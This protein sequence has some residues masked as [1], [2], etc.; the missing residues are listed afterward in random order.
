MTID[1]ANEVDSGSDS[2]IITRNARIPAPVRSEVTMNF[3]TEDRRMTALIFLKVLFIIV[4]F[5]SC[6]L[7]PGADSNRYV[8]FWDSL[9]DAFHF[10]IPKGLDY[11]GQGWGGRLHPLCRTTDRAA[12]TSPWTVYLLG[13]SLLEPPGTQ[14][15]VE[16]ELFATCVTSFLYLCFQ[17]V[18]K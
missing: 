8:C 5:V 1:S 4:N 10:P 12:R 17:I 7:W 6:S 3:V 2:P 15:S 16:N 13:R 18:K 11:P 14:N 9:H